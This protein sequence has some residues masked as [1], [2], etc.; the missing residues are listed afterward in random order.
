M[1]TKFVHPPTIQAFSDS[2]LTKPRRPPIC[3]DETLPHCKTHRFSC[4]S[5]LQ[6]WRMHGGFPLRPCCQSQCLRVDCKCCG[7]RMRVLQLCHYR[8]SRRANQIS[9]IVPLPVI[10]SSTLQSTASW[11]PRS[12]RGPGP[13]FPDTFRDNF[14]LIRHRHDTIALYPHCTDATL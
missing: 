13:L 6:I 1:G 9:R 11:R 2:H 4:S 5:E 8:T 10:F 3:Q 14:P 12:I 7:S